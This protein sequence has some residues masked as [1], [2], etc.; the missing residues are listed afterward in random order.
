MKGDFHIAEWAVQPQLNSIQRGKKVHHLEPKVMQVLLQLV[1]HSNEVLSKER[2]IQSV[3]P[4]TFVGEDVLT[5]SIS[6]IRRAFEDDAR[7]PRV[8]QT[9]PKTGYRLIAPVEFDPEETDP[10]SSLSAGHHTAAASAPVAASSAPVAVLEPPAAPEPPAPLPA[11]PPRHSWRWIAAIMVVLLA[12]LGAW[13]VLPPRKAPKPLR[14]LRT[15]PFTS[16]PGYQSQPAFS[17]DG[18]QI[19]FVWNG[20]GRDNYDIYVKVIGAETPLRLTTGPENDF[21]PAWS[22]DGRF[23]AYMTQSDS[24]S[25]IFLLPA[26]GGAP[27]KLFT[28][29]GS[30]EWDRGS[31]SWSPDGKNLI[32][33]DGKS[34]N[35]PSQIFQ[36]STE[37]LQA[38]PITTPPAR[39][40]G[41]ISPVYSPDGRQL[42]FIRA[43]EAAIRDVYV[44]NADGSNLRR[45]TFD[46]RNIQ[47]VAWDGDGRSVIFSSDRGGRPSLWRLSLENGAAPERIEV[48]SD[49]ASFPA[50]APK[51]SRIAYAQGKS[52][53]S[54]MQVELRNGTAKPGDARLKPFLSSTLQDSSPHYSPDGSRL[55]FQS[56]RAGTQEIWLCNSDGTSPVKLTSFDGPLTGS[57]NWSPDGTRIAF[58]ARPDGH[59]HV[60]AMTTAGSMPK[61]ITS[62]DSN[63]I[64]PNWSADGRWIY[65]GSN[66]SGSWQVWKVPS[67]GGDAVQVTHNGAFI[68]AE[69]RDGRWLYYTKVDQPGLWRMATASG[70]EEKVLDAPRLG[71]W[72]YWSL[73]GNGVYYLRNNTI[74][75]KNTATGAVSRILQLDH[76][77]PPFA[78]ITVAPDGRTLLYTDSTELSSNI[79]LVENFE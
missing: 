30:I 29:H 27:R 43:I 67:E 23:I 6:E 3:W 42:A 46:N 62:G 55:A 65:F 63:D 68:A 2:L 50:V 53:W 52:N 32:F 10:A 1:T 33:P 24:D 36:L 28:P 5:R 48:G 22:P 61:A 11:P 12:G 74:E 73:G 7:A 45:V 35:S 17:P 66:R 25:G 44:M 26:N 69:S 15:V 38:R 78:G 8:I 20:A 21:S 59:S 54:I 51:G 58:D 16:Y 14:A 49:D 39:W 56:W 75:F 13:R 71:Y 70:T 37:T 9:I 19:A 79:T 41:D 31:L 76:T 47:S 57:P 4:D 72:G 40:D 60:Y 64:V 77:P 18:N 34:A